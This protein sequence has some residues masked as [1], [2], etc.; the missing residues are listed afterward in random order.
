MNSSLLL[1][2]LLPNKIAVEKIGLNRVRSSDYGK[3]NNTYEDLVSPDSLHYL[4]A[5]D[6]ES[7]PFDQN[8]SQSIP[9]L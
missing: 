5:F 2:L 7:R 4:T 1:I 8:P 3:R 6:F 9:S